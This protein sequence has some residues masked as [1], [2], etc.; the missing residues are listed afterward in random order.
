[1][2]RFHR[3]YTALRWATGPCAAFRIA[4]A[5]TPRGARS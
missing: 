4:R 3:L 2:S 5:L 1:M